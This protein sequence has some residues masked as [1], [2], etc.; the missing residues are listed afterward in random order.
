MEHIEDEVALTLRRFERQQRQAP[1]DL[2]PDHD[3]IFFMIDVDHFKTVNDT[4]GHATGDTV[5]VEVAQRL[6]GVVRE[7][8]FLVRWGGEE[9]LLVARATHAD[10][11]PVLAERLRGAVAARPFALGDG[12]SLTS[13]CSI[14]FAGYPFYPDEPRLASWSEITRLADQAL[15][16]AKKEGR[17][18]WVGFRAADGAADR[19]HFEQVCRDPEAAEGCGDLAILRGDSPL[20]AP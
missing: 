9:F 5:L 13:T 8:D 11:G 7:T 18:R 4:H 14:G 1:T 12:R 3:L 20:T 6:R 15:Y 19:T 2:V 16:L 17:D 10:E